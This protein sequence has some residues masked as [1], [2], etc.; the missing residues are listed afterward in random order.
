MEL[1]IS[2]RPLASDLPPTC[3]V[4]YKQH[5]QISA[6]D[7]LEQDSFGFAAAANVCYSMPFF[8]NSGFVQPL[9]PTIDGI[10]FG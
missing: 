3:F 7:W 2:G 9:A 10:S 8:T 6:E 1:C 4:L 5:L